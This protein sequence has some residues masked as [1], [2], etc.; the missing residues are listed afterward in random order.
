ML[1]QSWL[2]PTPL[3]SQW[4]LSLAWS[5]HT[6]LWISSGAFKPK[7]G[8]SKGLLLACPVPAK[9]ANRSDTSSQACSC[10][11]QVRSSHPTS[12]LTNL[13]VI[14]RRFQCC[15]RSSSITPAFYQGRLWMFLP[16]YWQLKVLLW[17]PLY[18]LFPTK[19]VN[20]GTES[21]LISCLMGAEKKM[22][23]LHKQKINMFLH[24]RWPLLELKSNNKTLKNHWL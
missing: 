14:R 17:T 4:T 7:A 5:G 22:L 1:S 10:K 9:G 13:L 18:C 23:L 3:W 8:S 15:C 2:H 16:V 24:P 19:N 12:H 11:A 21:F 6:M 20:H